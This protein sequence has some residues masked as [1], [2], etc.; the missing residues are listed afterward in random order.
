MLTSHTG[1]RARTVP[2]VTAWLVCVLATALG[3]LAHYLLAGNNLVAVAAG[4][5]VAAAVGAAVPGAT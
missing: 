3:T 5:G 4:I 2:A 1:A